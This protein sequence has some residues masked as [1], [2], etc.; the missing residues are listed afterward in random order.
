MPLDKLLEGHQN[1]PHIFMCGSSMRKPEKERCRDASMSERVFFQIDEPYREYLIRG[2]KFYVEQGKS[3]LLSQFENISEAADK[4]ADEWLKEAGE[5][6]N[7]DYDDPGQFYERAEAEAIDFYGMLVDLRETTL[8]SITAGMYHQWEKL[9]RDFLTTEI[10]K[11]HVGEEFPR[12]VWGANFDQI[13][14]LLKSMGW[15][16]AATKFYESLDRC[17]LVV[18]VF[19]HGNGGSFK[20]LCDKHPEFFGDL[21]SEDPMWIH[22]DELKVNEDH[23]DE[24]SDAIIAFWNEFPDELTNID[25]NEAPEWV[26]KAIH[27]DEK[28]SAGSAEAV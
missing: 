17:R 2:Q 7:P 20:T 19:K 1:L 21:P 8:L 15:D 4:H 12:R 13:I 26:K 24:F 10:N 14:E 6:F 9:L 11:W 23:L 5:W 28:K 18:N 22:F 3:R 25:F 27:K 16:I